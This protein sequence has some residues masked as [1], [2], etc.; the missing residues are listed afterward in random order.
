MVIFSKTTC[1]FC[2]RVKEL[3][4]SLNIPYEALELDTIEGG[5]AIQELLAKKTGQRTVPN[6]FVNGNHVGGNDDTHK[7]HTAGKLVPM[8]KGA[9]HDY[10]NDIFVI[11][12]CS[13]GLAASKEAARSCFVF[14][15]NIWFSLLCQLKHAKPVNQINFGSKKYRMGSLKLLAKLKLL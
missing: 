15:S 10:Q 2:D 13:G 7:L 8:V 5:P 11:G 4:T 3:F 6:V 1:P 9:T 14:T 12:G